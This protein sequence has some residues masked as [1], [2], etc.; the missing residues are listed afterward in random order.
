MSTHAKFHYHSLAELTAA[1]DEL[2]LDLPAREDVSILLEPVRIGR[3]EAPNRLLIHP[4]EGC[5]ASAEGAPE[6]LTFRR[7]ERFA[8]GGAGT[9]WMEATA[10]AAAGRAN[11]RQLMLTETTVGAFA[12]LLRRTQSAA[13]RAG[14]PPAM[15]ILQLTHSGRYSKPRGRPEPIIAHHSP[16]LDPLVGIDATHPLIADEELDALQDDYVAAARLAAEVGFDAVDVKACH[17]YLI[18]ELLASHTRTG[19]RYGGD[20]EGRTRMLRETSARIVE[21]VG[22]R[23]DLAC[24]LNVYD[25]LEHPYGWGTS[26]E[27]D[28]RG[29]PAVDLAEPLRLAGELKETGLKCLSVTAGNPYWRPDVNRPADWTTAEARTPSEH[30]LEGVARLTNLAGQIQRAR[31]EL[32]VV[33]AGLS[34]LREFFPH[35]AAAAVGEGKATLAGLG[36]GALAYPDFAADLIKRGRLEPGKTCVLCSS[37]SQIMRDGGRAGCVIRDSEVYGPIYRAGRRRAKDTLRRAA[38]RCRRCVQPD[39]REVCPAGVDIPRFLDALAADDFPTAYA[40]L[41]ESLLL[42]AACGAVCPSEVTCQSGCVH[43][44]LG[45]SPVPVGELHRWVGEFA[46]DKGWAKLDLPA[47]AS[48]GPVAVVGAGPAGLACA[49]R[50]LELGH[51]VTVI[52]RAERPGGK[53][54]SAIPAARLGRDLLEREID[55][56]FAGIAPERL[57]WRMGEDFG[58]GV[59]P[60]SLFAEGFA[61]VCLAVGLDSAAGAIPGRCEGVVDAGSL[62]AEMN[63]HPGYRLDGDVA[64]IGGGNTAMDAAVLAAERGAREVFLLY[65]RSWREMPAWP[66]ERAELL[67]QGVHLMVLTQPIGYEA[68]E[69][70]RLAGV[71]VVRTQ[72]A[73]ADASGRRRPEPMPDSEFL[74]PVAMAVEAMGERASASLADVLEGVEFEAGRPVADPDTGATA[75]PGLYLA[76]DLLNGGTTVAQALGEGRRAAIA[77]HDRLSAVGG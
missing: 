73:E 46:I 47:E 4:M 59:T 60:E 63:L 72:L 18:S 61:A 22:D 58:G 26:A 32:P 36:R 17:R 74:L 68:D 27:T 55:A 62:L 7:Y 50:L 49:A 39:C 1:V 67:D 45:R 34:W 76:G 43:H 37:C 12:E 11:P 41:R 2:G 33:G 3:R 52:D 53:L 13:E 35:F 54:L 65:R 71:R 15:V 38:D 30:P 24:R 40:V 31:P 28:E 57:N 23:I 5:D 8:A 25:R 44:T 29:V 69:A 42:P 56:V 66:S 14:F 64:V 9:I 21:T 16:V 70:G 19:S 6:D 77:I 75:R 48:G 20:Y 51:P 10:V